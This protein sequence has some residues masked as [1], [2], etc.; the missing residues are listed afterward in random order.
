MSLA[1]TTNQKQNQ[2]ENKNQEC[3][4]QG[5]FNGIGL[6]FPT[7]MTK[8][9]FSHMLENCGLTKRFL[10]KTGAEETFNQLLQM[11]KDIK[12]TEDKKG[13]DTVEDVLDF[14]RAKFHRREGKPMERVDYVI[15]WFLLL[16]DLLQCGRIQ[17]DNENG[18]LFI[19]DP[20]RFTQDELRDYAIEELEK[21]RILAQQQKDLQ[22]A[23]N[24]KKRQAKKA[25]KTA[26]RTE[27]GLQEDEAR[28]MGGEDINQ[29]VKHL[30]CMEL[31]AIAH[32]CEDYECDV[33]L[34][35]M[36]HITVEAVVIEEVFEV[37]Y[38]L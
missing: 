22:K 37:A 36:E 24:D 30:E 13:C 32:I 6:A 31:F 20:D 12:S 10:N 26:G 9:K 14:C 33:S 23:K 28:S 4:I 3:M 29:A 27:Q 15:I 2:N 8:Q 21:R 7:Y 34:N 35:I 1:K 19:E 16:N 25:K 11:S 38:F 17:D 18:I 5:I